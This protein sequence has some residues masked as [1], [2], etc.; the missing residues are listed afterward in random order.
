MS[1]A[2]GIIE[3]ALYSRLSTNTNIM[4]AVGA[5]IYQEQAP[6]KTPLDYIVFHMVDGRDDNSHP[7]RSM[8]FDYQF[9]VLSANRA[10]ARQIAGYIDD[11]LHLV[12]LTLSGGWT[13]YYIVGTRQISRPENIDGS[14]VYRRIREFNIRISK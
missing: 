12:P 10:T 5:K 8:Q 1:D 14:Q 11:A 3:T 13:N 6:D 9:D 4:A 7:T 2:Q